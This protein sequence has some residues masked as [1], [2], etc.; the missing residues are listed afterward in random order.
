VAYLVLLAG[1]TTSARSDDV[2]ELDPQGRAMLAPLR[3]ETL[4]PAQLFARL[5]LKPTDVV[6]DIG[7][8]PGFLTLPLAK[9][10][11]HGRVIATDIQASYLAAL[12]RRAKLAGVDN[13]ET[14]VVTADRPGL[15]PHSVDVAIVCQVDHYLRD[16]A[17]YFSALA[18]TLRTGGRVVLVNYERY[19]AADVDAARAAGLRPVQE[20]SPSPPF[21]V[22]VL[23]PS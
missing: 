12:Q 3:N 21:F 16:R 23:K 11:P 13:I 8:G 19:R 1:L 2:S 22:L 5:A 14:R 20:W 4:Q 15:D 10:V 6:A 18:T 17:A 9:A 7:A